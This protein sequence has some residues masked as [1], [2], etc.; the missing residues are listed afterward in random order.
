MCNAKAIGVLRAKVDV[1]FH[2]S[3]FVQLHFKRIKVLVSRAVDPAAVVR[4]NWLL[5]FLLKV[6]A[7]LGKKSV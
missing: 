6:M 7:A 1:A 4:L 5:G 2:E 3:V